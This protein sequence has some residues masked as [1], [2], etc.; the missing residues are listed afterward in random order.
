MDALTTAGRR[1]RIL[2]SLLL[3]L[4]LA[5]TACGGDPAEDTATAAATEPTAAVPTSAEPAGP[6]APVATGSDASG[7]EVTGDLDSKPEITLPGGE[8]PAELVVVDLV[9]GDGAEAAV[10]A[11]VTTHYV[12]VSWRNGGEQFDAS[13]DRGEPATF[14]LSGVISGWSEGIPGMREG[15]RRLLVI[16]PQM[17]YG[18]TPPTAAIA[19]DD[20]LVFVIDLL[21]AT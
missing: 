12:G 10:G 18:S 4:A 13:W 17:G 19:V 3:A 14:P 6:V 21:A 15:G 16:P 9:E 11:T 7:V 2:L 5:G 8:P 20:T 1:A